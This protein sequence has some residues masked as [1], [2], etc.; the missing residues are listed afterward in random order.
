MTDAPKTGPEIID[1]MVKEPTL[2]TFL[3]RNPRTMTDEDL[4]QFI[5]L[6]RRNRAAYIEKEQSK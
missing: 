5:E 2:D 1:E 3:D 4:R 6:Q